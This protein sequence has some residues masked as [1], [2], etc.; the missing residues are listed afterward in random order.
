MARI[1]L[2]N[3]R[4]RAYSEG[5]IPTEFG[6]GDYTPIVGAIHLSRIKFRAWEDPIVSSIGGSGEGEGGGGGGGETSFIIAAVLSG[7]SGSVNG[8]NTSAPELTSTQG[9]ALGYDSTQAYPPANGWG[10]GKPLFYSFTAPGNGTL[11]IETSATGVGDIND[12]MFA[13]FTDGALTSPA[14]LIDSDDDGGVAA[15]SLLS[16]PV[17]SGTTYYIAVDGYNNTNGDANDPGWDPAGASI[18]AFTLTWNFV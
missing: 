3:I 2:S 1:N 8:N 18:G 16:V 7:T 17:T 11:T 4:F 9:I 14:S 13:V 10:G 5:E 12:S 15:Y 6:P